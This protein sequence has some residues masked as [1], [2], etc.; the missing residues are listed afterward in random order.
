MR[1]TLWDSVILATLHD[2]EQQRAEIAWS[3]GISADAE[4]A[5]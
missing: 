1:N 3:P 5:G 4:Y 2:N